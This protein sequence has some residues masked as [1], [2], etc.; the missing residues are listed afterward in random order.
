[1]KKILLMLM[2]LVGM[3]NISTAVQLEGEGVDKLVHSIVY[4]PDDAEGS[5]Y[6]NFD[7]RLEV[8]CSWDDIQTANHQLTNVDEE[9]I[10]QNVFWYRNSANKKPYVLGVEGIVLQLRNLGREPITIEWS[11]S[12]F[13]LGSYFGL[14]FMNGMKFIDAG[15][16][17]KIPQTVIQPEEVVKVHL[18]RGDPYI[19]FDWTNGY[20]KVKVDG[21]LRALVSMKVIEAGKVFYYTFKTPLIV[22]PKY[23]YT[24]FIVE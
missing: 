2:L 12:R 6:K 7:N 24:S 5:A 19:D 11:E 20:A 9:D 10:P 15:N 4:H 1:M 23:A 21:S 8:V 16:P 14:P 18:W 13:Q 22:L 17:E 3:C